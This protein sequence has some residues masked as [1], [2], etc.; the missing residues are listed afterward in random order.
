MTWDAIAQ[1][2]FP[3]D[4]TPKLPDGTSDEEDDGGDASEIYQGNS[5]NLPLVFVFVDNKVLG[6]VNGSTSATDFDDEPSPND[7]E[8]E[9]KPKQQWGGA[10]TNP[11]PHNYTPNKKPLPNDVSLIIH[12]SFEAMK[13]KYTLRIISHLKAHSLRDLNFDIPKEA[14]VVLEGFDQAAESYSK[15]LATPQTNSL[16][17]FNRKYL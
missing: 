12:K 2:C 15:L 4:H 8:P 9:E 13:Q 3:T 6:V 5:C 17:C 11:R 16:S 14:V 10:S 7:E 1:I